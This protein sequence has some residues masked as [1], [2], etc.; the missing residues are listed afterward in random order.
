MTEQF[1]VVTQSVVGVN[2]TS[3]ANAFGTE[4]RFKKDLLIV[5]LKVI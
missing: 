2:V 5:D 4:R 3:P 1:S